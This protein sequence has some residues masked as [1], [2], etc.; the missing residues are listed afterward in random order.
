MNLKEAF[1]FQNKLQSLMEQA[2][3]ILS[4]ESNIT[5]T[6]TTYLRKKVM[7]EAENE[8]ILTEPSTPLADQINELADF[9]LYLLQQRTILAGAVRKAKAGMDVDM[10]MEAGLNKERQTTAAVFR[11]MAGL[12]A[13]ES[14]LAGVGMGYRFNAEGN[15]VSYRCD[16]KRVTTIH[17]DRNKIRKLAAGL[18][19]EADAASARLD[20]ALV[21]TQ[22]DY[23]PPFD[24]N[25]TFED[26]FE[27]YCQTRS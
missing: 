19:E 1:R 20:L 26:I 7:P 10:D 13:S 16:M 11:F 4:D 24:V 22:V 2:R 21:N 6:E 9:L 14:L 23:Q 17:F 27:G 18:F 3:D 25:E 15:Q 5:Q 8:T 12:R